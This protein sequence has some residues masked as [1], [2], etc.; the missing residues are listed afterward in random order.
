V[1]ARSRS[2]E[3]RDINYEELRELWIWALRESG[4]SIGGVAP[5]EESLDLRSTDRHCKSFVHTRDPSARFHVSAA[6]GFCWDALQTAR[7]RCNEEDVV[8][9]LLGGDRGQYPRTEVPR[10]RVDV[11]L[12]AT[13]E[14]GK[15]IPLPSAEVWKNWARETIGRLENIE[16]LLPIEQV[17]EDRKG[18]LEILAFRSEPELHVLCKLDGTLVLRGVELAAWQTIQL[19][20][21]WD[22]SS[23]KP[24]PG[25]H[26]QLA[27]LL[28]RLKASLHGWREALDHLSPTN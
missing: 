16:P 3:A 1:R 4:L 5:I 22:D 2:C 7:T 8:R 27:A 23:R 25:P 6:L 14:W 21:T 11:T 24:D 19:P 9:Q 17:R 20:R 18:N 12:S 13:T 15:E 26:D 28:R 10:L